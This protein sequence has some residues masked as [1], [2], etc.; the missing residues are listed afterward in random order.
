MCGD[1]WYFEKYKGKRLDELVVRETIPEGFAARLLLTEESHEDMEVRTMRLY[2]APEQTIGLYSQDRKFTYQAVEGKEIG[3]DTARY[4]L[5][6]DGRYETIRT[7]GDGYWGCFLKIA[8][9]IHR[10][11][12]VDGLILSLDIPEYISYEEMKGYAKY[13]FEDMEPLTKEAHT[14]G[15]RWKVEEI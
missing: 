13:F 9:K 6:V 4:I 15:H 11:E 3:V 8:P 2:L 1:P 12:A 10:G 7:G 5:E 14:A